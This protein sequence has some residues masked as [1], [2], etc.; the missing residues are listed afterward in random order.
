VINRSIA[1]RY[2]QAL[3]ELVETDAASIAARLVE[4]NE[5]LE[6]N[7]VLKEVLVSPAFRMDERQKV[8]DQIIK[9]L[10][11]GKPI[12]RFL[13]YLVEHRRMVWLGAIVESFLKKLDQAQG[14]VR[15]QV[16]SAQP[17][18][19]PVI[20]NL[21]KA[22]ADGLKKEVIVETQVE[23]QVLAGLQVRIG[24]LV[25]DGSLQ[26]QLNNL[27]DVLTKH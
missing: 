4:F 9:R 21:K 11:W 25:V 24:D 10:G 27:K 8:F 13:W 22:L 20:A 23:P 19:E 18:D 3:M 7:P 12:D 6:A 1:R 15:V 5:L 2:A 14:R 17:L 26:T 16:T